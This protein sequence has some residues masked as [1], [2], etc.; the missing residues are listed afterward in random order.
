[1]RRGGRE[2]GHAAVELAL[3]VGLLLLPVAILVLSFP[4]W[5][6]RQSMAR[7]AARE[8]ARIVVLS[9]DPVQG[10]ATAAHRLA[11]IAH[12]HGVDP[13]G[14]TLCYAVHAVTE[15]APSTCTGLVRVARGEA[16]TAY[17]TVPL[18]A[19][20]FPGL[21]IRLTERSFTVTHTERVDLYRSW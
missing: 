3:A 20:E 6:E 4:T 16:V 17:V 12:N 18:P 14:V 15:A 1:V 9:P 11:D 2:A 21:P 10:A 8:V 7:S 19:L 13:A 5:I